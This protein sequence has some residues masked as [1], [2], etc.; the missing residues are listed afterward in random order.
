[1]VD[2]HEAERMTTPANP[3]VKRCAHEGCAC[4]V[5]PTNTH[6]SDHCKKCDTTT[7][8][9]HETHECHCHHHQCGDHKH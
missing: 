2:R 6:C 3:P 8:D 5:T 7:K 4:P 9:N 1:M